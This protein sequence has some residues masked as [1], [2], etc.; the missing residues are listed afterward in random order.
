MSA[1]TDLA[2]ASATPYARTA[3]GGGSAGKSR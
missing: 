3:P 2:S 1:R